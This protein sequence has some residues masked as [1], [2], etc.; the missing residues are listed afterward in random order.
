MTELGWRLGQECG[1][2]A[3]VE[4]ETAWGA[5]G[6]SAVEHHCA[7][8]VVNSDFSRQ[9]FV[10]NCGPFNPMGLSRPNCPLLRPHPPSEKEQGS[11]VER[12]VR[13]Y[14]GRGYGWPVVKVV[15]RVLEK[16]V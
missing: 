16:S 1:G 8:R 6:S 7:I 13:V 15:G 12:V 10:V 2:K 3:L 5:P 14:K 4:V 9:E 11:M